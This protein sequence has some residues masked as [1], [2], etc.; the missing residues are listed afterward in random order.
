[1]INNK[2]ENLPDLLSAWKQSVENENCHFNEDGIISDDHW[3]TTNLKVLFVLKETNQAKQNIISAI[4]YAIENKKSCW[5]RGKVLSRVGRWAYGLQNYNEQPIDFTCADKKKKT[6]IPAIAYINL[7]KSNGGSRTKARP[8]DQHVNKYSNLI[9]QQ[10]ELINPDV[11]VLCGTY[12]PIKKHVFP[13]LNKKSF[14]VHE[15]ENK[16]FINAWHP[17]CRKKA[18]EV[19][20]QVITN[21]HNYKNKSCR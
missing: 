8:F 16:I 20:E 10:I 4:N 13:E 2:F 18:N 9:K 6:A 12:K 19:Y 3:C 21:F 1:M 11:I 7:R 17:A 14:R 5:W 15:F